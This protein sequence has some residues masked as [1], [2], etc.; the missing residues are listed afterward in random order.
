MMFV[1]GIVLF[2][3]GHPGLGGAAR[4]RPHVGGARHRNEGPPL[5]RRLRPHAVVDQRPNKLGY[6]E[7]GLKAVPLGGFCDI[8]G[9]TSVE[10]L[11]P[12]GPAVRD[13]GR[14][15]EAG[16]GAVRRARA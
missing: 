7:Y 13:V 8:A 1:I 4:M 10:E 9:M 6:T 12:D 11:A 2:A 5:L 16:R 15:L 3:A 14:D